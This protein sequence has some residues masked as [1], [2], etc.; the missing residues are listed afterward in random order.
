MHRLIYY[1]TDTC[2]IMKKD[3]I[4]CFIK[5]NKIKNASVYLNTAEV[6]RFK[7]ICLT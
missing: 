5:Y 3:Y 4:D 1:E 6:F 7:N 2:L